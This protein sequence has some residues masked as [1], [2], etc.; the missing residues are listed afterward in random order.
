MSVFAQMARTEAS[1]RQGA[2]LLL[3]T[4][5]V[6]LLLTTLI[7]ASRQVYQVVQP[8]PQAQEGMT[9]TSTLAPSKRGSVAGNVPSWQPA[10]AALDSDEILLPVRLS[11]SLPAELQH[12]FKTGVKAVSE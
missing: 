5:S 9:A 1:L 12:C 2:L 11:H 3:C 10:V 6:F 7:A 8:R 4:A